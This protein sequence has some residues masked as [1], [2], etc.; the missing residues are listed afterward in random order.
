MP[1]GLKLREKIIEI[2]NSYAHHIAYMY[3]YNAY[4]TVCHTCMSIMP[5]RLSV[6]RAVGLKSC[7]ISD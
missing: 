1:I 6:Y 4:K 5:I 7:R 2:L 3:V